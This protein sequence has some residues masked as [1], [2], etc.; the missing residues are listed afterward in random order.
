MEKLEFIQQ[1]NIIEKENILLSPSEQ[2]KDIM[3]Q[4]MSKRFV[5]NNTW[6]AI[7]IAG[8][9]AL[10]GLDIRA[11]LKDTQIKEMQDELQRL[12][13]NI[14]KENNLDEH[15]DLARCI[16]RFQN[17][18]IAF[19]ELNKQ[20]QN[21]IKNLPNFIRTT[22]EWPKGHLVYM[23]QIASALNQNIE[24]I[25]ESS[26]SDIVRQ[27]IE[28]DIEKQKN[29]ELL[30]HSMIIGGGLLA[31]FDRDAAEKLIQSKAWE[32]GKS[33]SDILDYFKKIKNNNNG[34]Q[35]ARLLPPMQALIKLKNYK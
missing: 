6:D 4:A 31:Q 34:W 11:L 13:D 30:F 20:E 26:D 3:L 35:L 18:G 8:E 12:R 10:A 19:P 28:L 21:I 29:D 23:P 25:K 16:Y 14:K 9:M 1:N 22:A 24:S 5:E 2:D 32:N 15:I 17:I 27:E 33:W 7:I